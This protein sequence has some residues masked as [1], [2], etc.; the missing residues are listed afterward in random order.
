MFSTMKINV[1][2]KVSV[3]IQSV[4]N[5]QWKLTTIQIYRW[6]SGKFKPVHSL[7]WN[8]DVLTLLGANGSQSYRIVYYHSWICLLTNYFGE[9]LSQ[10]TELNRQTLSDSNRWNEI[11]ICLLTQVIRTSYYEVLT[12][13]ILLTSYSDCQGFKRI[14]T[15]RV[16]YVVM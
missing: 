5:I 2:Q 13:L 10:F 16:V 9:I 3:K 4:T 15:C 1:S 6:F 7:N 12:F 8:A 14:S 11:N